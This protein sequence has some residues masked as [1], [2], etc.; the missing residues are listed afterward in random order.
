MRKVFTRAGRL[1]AAWACAAAMAMAVAA[2]GGD[3]PENGHEGGGD[4]QTEA[5]E[6]GNANANPASSPYLRRLEMPRVAED[7]ACVFIPHTTQENGRTVVSFSVEQATDVRHPRWVAFTFDATTAKDAG[8]GRTG[9]FKADPALGS[10]LQSNNDDFG[11]GGNDGIDRGHLCASEDRQYSREANEQTFYFTNMSPQYSRFNQQVWAALEGVVQDWG[12]TY[13]NGTDTLFVAKGGTIGRG[14]TLSEPETGTMP[15]YY[16]MA[17]LSKK[18]SAA[19]QQFQ[20]RAIGF[21]L[22]QREQ[23]YQRPYRFSQYAMA[24]DRLE[25]ETGIDFFCNL[26]D[27]VEDSVEQLLNLSAWPGLQ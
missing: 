27:R 12:R 14:M 23:A 22:E 21:L 13:T 7:G 10:S 17:L 8:V 5:P 25:E 4:G 19:N 9:K 24:I 1:A 26:P 3:E 6:A 16:Y 11:T 20:Y 18:W 15:R 2:C